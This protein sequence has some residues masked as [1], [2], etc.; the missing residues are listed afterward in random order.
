MARSNPSGDKQ[1]PFWQPLRVRSFLL[2]FIG[3]N[4]SLLGNQFYL[5]A[6]PWL[7]IQLT[8]SGVSLGTVLMAAAI[9]R[10][11]LLLLGGVVSD[12]LKPRIV[13]I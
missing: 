11:A 9:P 12:R 2:L 10:A 8:D 1:V 13:M 5:V 6:L 7:T 3:E 4:I